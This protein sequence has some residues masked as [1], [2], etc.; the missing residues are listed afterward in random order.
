MKILILGHKGLIGSYLTN[1]IPQAQTVLYRYPSSEFIKHI[2]KTKY[3]I[4]INCAVNKTGDERTNIHLPYF[5]SKHCDY[6]I[7]FSSDAVFSGKKR[8]GETYSKEDSTDPIC[9]YGKQKNK[10]EQLLYTVA[11]K[12]L[13]IRTSFLDNESQFVKKILTNAEFF[14]F[15]NYIWSGLSSKQVANLTL[16]CITQHRTGICHMFSKNSLSKYKLALKIS[17]QFHSKTKIIPTEHPI[18]N[19]SIKSDFDISLNI[20]D[21]TI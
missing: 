4:I 8:I 2:V 3:N 20:E 1:Y 9:V 16:S 19:R 21:L 13:I 5:L 11:D 12:S 6:L 17:E 14:A 10:M 15:K 7:Q 18:I